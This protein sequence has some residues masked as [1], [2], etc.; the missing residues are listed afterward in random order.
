MSVCLYI[1]IEREREELAERL[2][3]QQPSAYLAIYI[4]RYLYTYMYKL[5]NRRGAGGEARGAAAHK[6]GRS[7]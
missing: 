3:A 2:E 5:I 1:Y 7:V 6:G 4:H